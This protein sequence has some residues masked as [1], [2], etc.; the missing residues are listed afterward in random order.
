MEDLAELGFAVDS[1]PLKA[2]NS[3]LAKMP[4]NAAGAEKATDKLND[5]FDRGSKSAGTFSKM[6]GGLKNA[7]TGLIA[8]FGVSTLIDITNTWT[9]LNSRVKIATGS[10]EA[11]AA[12]MERLSEMARRTYSSLTLTAEGFLLNAKALREL[13]YTTSQSLDFIESINNALVVSGAK[14]ERAESVM[15][16]LSKAMALGKLSGD[17]LETVLASGG[18]VTQ[19]L[20]EGLGVATTDLRKMG[21]EGKLTSRVLFDALISQFGKL[22][23]EAEGMPATIGD[24]FVLIGNSILQYVGQVDQATGASQAIAGVLIMVADN[25]EMVGSI[26]VVVGAALLTAFGPTMVFMVGT[27]LVGAFVTLGKVIAANPI[28]FLATVLVTVITAVWQFRDAIKQAFGIDVTEIVKAVGNFM[29][30]TFFESFERIKYI[31]N[32]L[33]A[34]VGSAAIG[35]TN[36]V[37]GALNSMISAAVTGINGLISMLPKEFGVSLV[38]GDFAQ[39][40]K[41]VDGFTASINANTFAMDQNIKAIQHTDYVGGFVSAFDQMTS[42]VDSTS[43]AM[44]ALGGDGGDGSGGGGGATGKAVKGL[45]NVKSA[46]AEAYEQMVALQKEI[47]GAVGGAFKSFFKDIMNGK[48]AVDALTDAF[49]SLADKLMDMVLDQAING[50][51]GGLFGGGFGTLG[52][53]VGGGATWG[54]LQSF[55]ASAK[56]NAFDYRGVKMFANGGVVG[57]ATP[58]AH[59]SGMGVM[60]EK[61]PEG[62]LPLKRGSDGKL[63]VMNVANDTAGVVFVQPIINNNASDDVQAS[64]GTDDS[65]NLVV[66]IDKIVADRVGD[67]SSKTSRALSGSYGL[68][69]ATKSR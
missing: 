15:N 31:W 25:M 34:I 54:G 57:G 12:T 65:G 60:G 38:S 21:Q 2:A 8:A 27:A 44:D 46:A 1:A 23:E 52:N 64:A 16:A 29:V 30:R 18:R 10:N 26:A 39:I 48:N 11:A 43:A 50:I 49:G 41:V 56:G 22:R 36:A 55:L 3:E 17:Q 47:A 67:P 62:I 14:G 20:A 24:A 37:I 58:F 32:T 59:A 13:G 61:G 69:R 68:R 63:G 7:V 33:P 9:D 45:K 5:Q 51:I 6:V 42:A 28:G 4:R 53:D 35:A 19:A 40:P 66:T